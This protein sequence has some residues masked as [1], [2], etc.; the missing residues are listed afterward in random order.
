MLTFS[1]YKNVPYF[2]FYKILDPVIVLRDSD[3][4]KDILIK[5]FPNF[6]ANEAMIE[7]KD[8]PLLACNP[9]FRDGEQWKQARAFLTPLHTSSKVWKLHH[10]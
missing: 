9:S 6:Q 3:L 2:G 7:A 8:D 1:E 4:I 10:F 5:D